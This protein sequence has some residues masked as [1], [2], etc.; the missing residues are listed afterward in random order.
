[1]ARRSESAGKE[2]PASEVRAAAEGVERR[3][4]GKYLI[5]KRIGAGGMGTVYLALDT[6]LNRTVALKI[7]PKEKADNPMLVKRFKAEAQSAAQLKHDNVVTIY[8]AGRLDGLLFIALEY[9]EGTDV[10]ILLDR[11]G[12]LP[13]K[14][15]I[16]IVKQVARA[17]QHAH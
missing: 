10:Q 7:L 14:R 13:V 11:R 1:M 8:E 15:T 2:E 3:S 16:E 6:D 17:L 12:C 5:Q 4:L 9:V